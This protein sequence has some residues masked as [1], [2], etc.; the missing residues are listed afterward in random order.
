MEVQS[1]IGSL[2]IQSFTTF[3]GFVQIMSGAVAQLLSQTNHCP[4][5]PEL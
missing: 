1:I 4:L 2:F 5:L 3:N